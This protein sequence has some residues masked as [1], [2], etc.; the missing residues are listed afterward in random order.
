MDDK[1]YTGHGGHKVVGDH[2]TSFGRRGPSESSTCCRCG[3]D[4]VVNTKRRR[5]FV[6]C[7]DC[8]KSDPWYVRRVERKVPA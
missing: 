3:G 8:R 7:K 2:G 6:I 4:V 5:D 1:G